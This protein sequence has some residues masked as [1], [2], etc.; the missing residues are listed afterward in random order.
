MLL[1]AV[2]LL[3]G[4]ASAPAPHLSSL[5][6]RIEATETRLSVEI[7]AQGAKPA[8]WYLVGE[9]NLRVASGEQR[10]T[11]KGGVLRLPAEHLSYAYSLKSRLQRSQS[12]ERGAGVP[13]SFV[14]RGDRYLLVPRPGILL[15]ETRVELRFKGLEPFLPWPCVREG[16]EWVARLYANDLRQLGFHAFGARRRIPLQLEEGARWEVVLLAGDLL[17]SDE[18]I[19]RWI[20]EAAQ[21]AARLGA[22]SP[23][24]RVAIV[25]VPTPSG[26][27]APFGRVLYSEPR[28]AAIYVGQRAPERSFAGDWLAT[29]E[30]MHTLHPRF[31]GQPRWLSEGIAAYYQ[32]LAPIRSGRER[33]EVLWRVL[34][35]GVA[36]GQTEALGRSLQEVAKAM[37]TLP[38][39]SA[40]YWGGALLALEVDLEIRR[41]TEGKRGLEHVLAALR[42]RGSVT[43]REFGRSVDALAGVAIWEQIRRAHLEGQ[44]LRRAK[45]LLRGLGIGPGG[46]LD[47]KAPGAKW[48]LRLERG[49]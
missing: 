20:Q 5:V 16:E 29:H 30:L 14:V 45:P 1:L 12:L 9:S 3:A 49:S 48:R 36:T 6:Y 32:C 4:C 23:R 34:A 44:A 11:V 22:G 28:S 2:G 35:Q 41:A 8:R 24:E 13:G 42:P 47:S 18:R 38:A 19:E 26:E 39:Y 21:E 7:E 46:A 15:P 17:A 10:A 43:L 33:P 31:D 40:V 37:H 25:L 27:P